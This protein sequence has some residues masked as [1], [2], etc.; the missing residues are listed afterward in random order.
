MN[1]LIIK[2][3]IY[4]SLISVGQQVVNSGANEEE[5]KNFIKELAPLYQKSLKDIKKQEIISKDTGILTTNGRVR[6]ELPTA[7]AFTWWQDA[8]INA[9]LLVAA[10]GYVI[11]LNIGRGISAASLVTI[12]LGPQVT[13]GFLV[14]MG[15]GCG[16]CT[17]PNGALGYYGSF[18]GVA[19]AIASISLTLQC[20]III[21]GKEN[22]S[23][24]AW[25]AGIDG[26]EE[27]V[28]NAA[29]LLSPDG[30]FLGITAGIGIG[31]GIPFEEFVTAQHTWAR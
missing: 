21:G 23:G 1:E 7:D 24:W 16:L 27:I 31:V 13:G 15:A 6:V 29:A 22:F 4:E 8:L 10:P 25:G 5:V 14:G 17:Y 30:R 19:G 11:L 12:G 3:E 28:G 18:G 2:N 26:G 20:T 9:A